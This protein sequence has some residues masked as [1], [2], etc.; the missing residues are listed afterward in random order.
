VEAV[1]TPEPASLFLF[2]AGAAFIAF[3]L[4]KKSA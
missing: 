3:R 1:A 4:R 2:G